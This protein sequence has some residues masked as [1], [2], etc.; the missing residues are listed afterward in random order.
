[1]SVACV[2][3]IFALH[4]PASDPEVT[5]NGAVELGIEAFLRDNVPPEENVSGEIKRPDGTIAHVVDVRAR[6]RKRRIDQFRSQEPAFRACLNI[7]VNTA[8]FV[9]FR[10]DDI[11]DAWE[12]EPSPDVIAAANASDDSRRIRDRKLGAL[13]KL[14][15]GDFTRVKICGRNLFTDTAQP[16]GGRT[17]GTSPR[18]HWRRGHWRRQ[19]HGIG[20]GLVVVRWIRPTIVM[21]DNGPLVEARIYEV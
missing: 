21:K 10:P 3:P 15:S 20:L 5:I 17:D 1:M 4:L 11:T 13:R 2:D 19:R 12:G 18:A 14:E 9:T 8:C 16:E 6:S 7:I